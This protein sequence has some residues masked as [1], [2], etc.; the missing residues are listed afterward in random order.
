MPVSTREKATEVPELLPVG[1]V[2]LLRS[3][4]LNIPIGSVITF[5]QALGKVGV[6][7]RESVYW[8]GRTTLITDPEDISVYDQ[9]FQI[10]WE[11]LIDVSPEFIPAIQKIT[12]VADD[13]TPIEEGAVEETQTD[14]EVINLRYSPSEILHDKDFALYTSEELDEAYELMQKMRLIGGFRMSRRKISSR[15]KSQHP[16]IRRTIKS[17]LR[18]DGEPIHQQFFEKGQR[19]RRVVFLLDVSGSM[20]TYA[21]AL[22]RF[23]Q[24]AVVGRRQ[25]EV[26]TLG[27]RLTRITRELSSRDLDRAITATSKAVE[28]WSG[29]TKLGETLRSFNNEWGQRGIAR[30]SV[31]VIL[32]D[33]WDRGDALVMSEQMQRL[34]KVSH[35]IIWVNPLKASPGYE[36]LA[37]GMAAA[38]PYVDRFIEG[39]SLDSLA[40]LASL[41]SE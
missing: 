9:A 7:D 24:A 25:V 36:P 34:Q 28:D 17:S 19:L 37:Q 30:G 38:L 4:G 8:A 15:R 27:T 16:D 18:T 33:G 12:L 31:V 29:G 3:L 21:R 1:F 10:F 41:L 35:Q 6:S 5:Q 22:L 26:F 40:N 14:G 11:G 39:H 23:V 32:S 2:S 13:E 20:E